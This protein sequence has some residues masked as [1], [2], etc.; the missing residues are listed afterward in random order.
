M[1]PTSEFSKVLALVIPCYNPVLVLV[2]VLVLVVA[3]TFLVNISNIPTSHPL[4]D[5]STCTAFTKVIT[6]WAR[7][8]F[9]NH[10]SDANAGFL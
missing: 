1:S 10:S 5:N 2:L 8:Y 4:S 9:S 7:F 6:N 3:D